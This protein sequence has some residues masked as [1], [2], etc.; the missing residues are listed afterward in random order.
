MSKRFTLKKNI[1][2]RKEFALAYVLFMLFAGCKKTIH[3]IILDD[4]QQTNLAADVNGYGA[5]RLD[6]NLVNA[7]GIAAAPSGPLWL[8]AAETGLS[9]IYDKTGAT[10]RPPVAIPGPGN[11]GKGA[12]TGVVFNATTDFAIL[13]GKTT[14]PSRFIF[15]TEDGTLA[16]WGPGTGNTAVIVADRSPW[17]AVYKGLAMASDGGNNFLYATNFREGKVDVFDKDFQLVTGKP[18]HDPAIPAGFAPFNIRLIGDKL[19]VTYAKQELPDKE[20]DEPG[21]GNGYVDI[22]RTNGVL[23]KRFAARGALNSPWGMVE[24]GT[25]FCKLNHAIL[26]G[27]FGDGRINMYD[28][29]GKLVGPLSSWGKPISIEGL[30]AL[31]N[32]IPLANPKQLFFT[33]GPG[34]ESH[35]LFGYLLKAH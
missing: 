10:L 21:P 26:I 25:P 24:S 4:Y 34:D 35:G 28:D 27:N 33:A 30:W 18:F 1:L 31:E 7:W 13:W 23:V 22:Y 6:P 14:T 16:A 19:F 8:S 9:T 20:D 2:L 15:A 5:A 29:N 3:E 32:K 12:P 17:E 11:T